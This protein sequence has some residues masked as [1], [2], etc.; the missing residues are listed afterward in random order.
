MNNTYAI[1]DNEGGWL[2]NLVLWDGNTETW[3]PPA[4]THAVPIEEVDVNNLPNNPNLS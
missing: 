4:G 2:V 3:S 1:I